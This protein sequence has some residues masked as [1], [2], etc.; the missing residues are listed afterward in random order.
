VQEI[1]N[2]RIEGHTMH[3]IWT[4]LQRIQDIARLMNKEMNSLEKKIGKI[5]ME[6]QNIQRQ[7]DNDHLNQQLIEQEKEMIVQA[8]KWEEINEQ[9]LRQKSR[10]VWIKFDDP[11]RRH[12]SYRPVSLLLYSSVLHYQ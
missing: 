10:T 6:L 9:V 5:R 3:F 12:V 2:Q 11:T 8:E 1:W 4:K 7:I